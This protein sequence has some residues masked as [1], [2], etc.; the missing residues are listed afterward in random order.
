VLMENGTL[1]S[2]LPQMQQVPF[3]ASKKTLT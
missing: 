1:L 2:E 3:M